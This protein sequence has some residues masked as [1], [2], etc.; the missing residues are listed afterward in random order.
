MTTDHLKF[1]V[2]VLN[3]LHQMSSDEGTNLQMLLNNNLQELAKLA[4]SVAMYE[5]ILEQF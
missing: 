2:T 5:Q 1:A 3:L 4:K